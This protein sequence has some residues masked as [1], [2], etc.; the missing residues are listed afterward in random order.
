MDNKYFNSEVA[1]N[2]SSAMSDII[3]FCGDERSF[4]NNKN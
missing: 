2:Q 3:R 1:D 4:I